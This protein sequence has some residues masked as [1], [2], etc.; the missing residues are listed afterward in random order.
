M[1]LPEKLKPFVA[2]GL[3]LQPGTG[4]QYVGDCPLC[5]KTAHLYV[6]SSTGQ[7]D[8]KSCG[9]SSNIP[10]FLAMILEISLET[11]EEKDHQKLAKDR[12]VEPASLHAWKIAK[13]PFTG[14]WIIPA[15]NI[16]GKLSNLYRYEEGRAISTPGCKL[17]PFRAPGSPNKSQDS[18][19]VVEGPW[20][21]IK[22]WEVLSKYKARGGEL[23][24]GAKL[25]RV[26]DPSVSLLASTAV[27]AAP[28][29][30]TFSVDWLAYLKDKDCFLGFDND[31]PK[32]TPSGKTVKPGWDGMVRIGK[33]ISSNGAPRPKSLHRIKWGEAG[34][35]KKLPKG[36]DIRDHLLQKGPAKGLLDLVKRMDRVSLKKSKEQQGKG[37]EA[38]ELEPIS[39]STFQDLVATYEQALHFTPILRDTL[40]C[41]LA[42][43]ISTDLRGEQLW[44]RIIGP[45][46]SGKTTLAEAIT[47]AKEY[48]FPLDI[49]TGGASGYKEP[50]RRSKKDASIIPQ[51]MGKTTIIK[52]GDTL[53]SSNDKGRIL[54]ELRALYDGALRARYR[55]L[56]SRVYEDVRT[57]ILICGTDDLRSLNRSSLGERFLDVEILGSEDTAPYLD[58]AIDN[59]YSAFL[60]SLQGEAQQIQ[61]AKDYRRK[62]LGYILYLKEN[63]GS[64]PPP[65]LPEAM[66]DKIHSLGSIL[67]YMRARVKKEGQELAYRPRPEIATRLVSQLSKLAG[68]LALVTGKAKVDAKLYSIVRK[69]ALDT[70]QGFQLE[71]TQLLMSHKVG[72][73]VKQIS[74]ELNIPETSVR[75]LT[76]DMQELSIIRRNNKPNRS[77]ARGRDLHLWIL[78]KEIR[79]LWTKA[80]LPKARKG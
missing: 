12:G 75:R 38:P 15:W 1:P 17:H 48:I 45:P 9:E 55:N 62:T 34:Y 63:L 22:L 19:W 20:D 16:K 70:A 76:A 2:H 31:Y 24:P 33:L 35:S 40:A 37:Q 78:T 23:K 36:Y 30:N 32:K 25:V 58:R 79:A 49:F 26:A 71:I 3:E 7:W 43:V 46:G 54:G 44:M 39:C 73:S 5:D 13:N 59:T 6:N 21:G 51:M 72:L 77:G 8:C 18:I 28:G 41:M 68:C 67:S 57:T 52:D 53:L 47:A 65:V 66:R 60:D 11:T 61:E 50:G 64:L 56:E 74:L 4:G 80:G 10:G 27:L 29:A 69:V 42:T 14:V